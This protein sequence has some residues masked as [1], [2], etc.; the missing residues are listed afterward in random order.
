MQK[1][2]IPIR[3]GGPREPDVHDAKRIQLVRDLRWKSQ[4]DLMLQRERSIEE[5]VRMLAG[6]QWDMWSTELG[7][8]VDPLRYL[9]D[10]ERA[11]RQFPVVDLLGYWFQLQHARLTENPPI[12]AFQPASADRADALLAETMDVL[13]KSIW[14]QVGML[15]IDDI[16]MRWVVAA[17]YTFLKSRWDFSKGEAQELIGPAMLSMDTP[18]GP[19]QRAIEAAPYD[20]QGNVLAQLDPEDPESYGVTGQPAVQR[21][22]AMDVMALSPL[23]CR[24][25]WSPSPWH[26]R[27]WHIH[28]SYIPVEEVWDL[29]NVECEPDRS[30]SGEDNGYLER[31]LFSAGYYGAAQGLLGA[32]LGTQGVG[33]GADGYVAVDECWEAPSGNSPESEESPGGR[34]LIVTKHKVLHDSVRPHRFKYTSP[35]RYYGFVGLPGRPAG[36]SPLEKLIPLQKT[37]NRGWKQIF[38]HRNLMTNPKT[39][40]EAGVEVELGN[41]PGEIVEGGMRDGKPVIGYLS[42]PALSGDVWR[43]QAE[44]ERV[45]NKIGNVEG[46]EGTPP[47]EDSSGELVKELRFNSDRFVAGTTRGKTWEDARMVEDWM[48]ILK[49]TMTEEEI[50]AHC[51]EDAVVTTVTILPEMWK[52]R[53]NVKPDI[54]S[55]LPEGRGER[56]QRAERMYDKGIFGLP[57][58]PEAVGRYLEIAHFPHQGRFARPGGVDRVTAEQNLGAIARGAPHNDPSVPLF[59]WYNYP[60][61][62]EVTRNFMAS[63]EYKRLDP[64]VQNEFVLYFEMLQGAALAVAQQAQAVAGAGEMAVAGQMAATQAQTASLTPPDPNAESSP[65]GKPGKKEGPD[66]PKKS[67]TRAA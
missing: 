28:R 46:A 50:I 60:V 22:G 63:P 25:E 42:P 67:K 30:A 15:E 3:E 55:A 31:L 9:S 44:I 39:L 6:R 7:K 36:S 54:E 23:E 10:T 20:A 32:Q 52:G 53:V 26:K 37:Y 4:D 47:T 29:Y 40:T 24:G 59:P 12:I 38:E 2:W 8:F 49:D 5:A 17:G 62:I 27:R 18:E 57:G 48:A 35:I 14:D 21:K 33:K 51:G 41:A 13:Y 45:F 43:T 19:I 64:Q 61:F 1:T 56:Q 11:W 65:P 66:A 34:L 58:S 16:R